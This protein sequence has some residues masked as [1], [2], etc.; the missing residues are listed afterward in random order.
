MWLDP[1]VPNYAARLHVGTRCLVLFCFCL[2]NAGESTVQQS[3][4]I[5]WL[6]R[7]ILAG[8]PGWSSSPEGQSIC[9]LGPIPANFSCGVLLVLFRCQ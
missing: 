5:S 4:E 7:V 6:E 1:M 3:S 8:S 9:D 2:F